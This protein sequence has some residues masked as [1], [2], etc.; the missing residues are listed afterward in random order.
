M[1]LD[2]IEEMTEYK[3][4]SHQ[5]AQIVEMNHKLRKS[6]FA[7]LNDHDKIFVKLQEQIDYLRENQIVQ[8]K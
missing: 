8:I 5:I 4:L 2:F 3:L 7:Q 6:I 1:Q